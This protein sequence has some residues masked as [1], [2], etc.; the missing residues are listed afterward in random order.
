MAFHFVGFRLT[1]DAFVYGDF[2]IDFPGEGIP[3]PLEIICYSQPTDRYTE[4]AGVSPSVCVQLTA[5]QLPLLPVDFSGFIVERSDDGGLTWL[6]V[7]GLV[8]DSFFYVDIPPTSGDYVYRAKMKVTSG[9]IGTAANEVPVLVGRWNDADDLGVNELSFLDGA[10]VKSLPRNL[11]FPDGLDGDSHTGMSIGEGSIGGGYGQGA[12]YIRTREFEPPVVLNH[13]PV[14]G[15]TGVPL[16][17]TVLTFE[18]HDN[19]YP[20]GGSGIDDA[21]ILLRLGVSSQYGGSL[22]TIRNGAVEPFSPAITCVVTP[23]ADPL[24]DRNV[25]ITVPVGYIQ[26]DDVVTI[27]TTVSDLDGNTAVDTCEFTMEHQD[28]VPPEITEE[29]P[30]CGTGLEADDDRRVPR[31]TT[32]SFR[33]YDS[34][35]GVDLITL[36]VFYGPDLIG[37]WTQVL[38]NGTTWFL[39]FSGTITPHPLGGYTVVVKRPVADPLWPADSIVCFR[40]QVQDT[41][42]NAAEEVCCFRTRVETRLNRVV[43]IAEDIIYVEF[44]EGMK[45]DNSLRDPQNYQIEPSVPQDHPIVIRSVSPHLF[46]DQADPDDPKN[47]LGVGNPLFVYLN[48]TPHSFWVKYELTINEKVLDRFGFPLDPTGRTGVYRGRR[49]KVDEG[50]D[51]IE[52]EETRGDSLTRRVMVGVGHADE[53]IGGSYV[54]DDWEES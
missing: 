19:P 26:T 49:T 14:C 4:K 36:Q 33:V 17:L 37:P 52:G 40:I 7:S 41:E 1:Q 34:D 5:P 15:L 8:T 2:S 18:I 31:D 54:G 9:A 13:N 11:P 45:N 6:D 21:T 23:G 48:T 47:R 38:Q 16:P 30:E 43:P 3:V 25:V 35:S 44:S 50:R 28:D 42:G 32:F 20:V 10:I 24:L 53:T 22:I 27:E 29:D 12:W 39:G 46:E 51:G